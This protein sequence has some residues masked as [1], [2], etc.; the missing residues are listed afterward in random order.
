MDGLQQRQIDYTI[1]RIDALSAL[2]AARPDPFTGTE[3]RE[4]E[5]RIHDIERRLDAFERHP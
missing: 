1:S 4:L 2:P 5:R 3:G